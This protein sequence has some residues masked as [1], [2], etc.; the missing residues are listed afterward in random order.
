[1]SSHPTI[2]PGLF[3]RAA[4]QNRAPCVKAGLNG[5]VTDIQSA[6]HN[7]KLLTFRTQLDG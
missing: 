7:G 3:I 4:R 6:V 2:D 1:M 5:E